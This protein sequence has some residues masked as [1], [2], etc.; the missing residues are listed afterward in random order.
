M[1][2]E[3]KPKH[4]ILTVVTLNIILSIIITLL[5]QNLNA[6]EQIIPGKIY[7]MDNFLTEI[8][9]HVKYTK[10]KTHR[11]SLK[12]IKRDINI[13]LNKFGKVWNQKQI[14]QL[15]KVLQQGET[16]FDIN[17]QDVLSIISVESEFDPKAFNNNENKTTDYGLTQINDI[18]WNRLSQTSKKILNK[19]DI[20]FNN[21]KYD[22]SLNVMNCF[23]YLN[24]S[25]YELKQKRVFTQKTLI[26]S[27]N[28]GINGS[29]SNSRNFIIKREAYYNKF[30]KNKNELISF[31]LK[32][33]NVDSSKI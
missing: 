7:V 19:Y 2:K 32:M 30:L 21:N 29:L 26:Q 4:F 20:S 16:Y 5:I 15:A 23:V 17:Y 22:I 10:A 33:Q 24:W 9:K 27:Y 13:F 8:D 14:Y 1:K 3:I 11:S 12:N 6:T 25:N 28:V 31:L 18:N